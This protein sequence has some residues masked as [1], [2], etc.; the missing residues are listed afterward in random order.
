MDF[1][2]RLRV[3]RHHHDTGLALTVQF[4][5][6]MVL[7]GGCDTAILTLETRDSIRYIS[8]DLC[9]RTTLC[10][11]FAVLFKIHFFFHNHRDL[12]DSF[13]FVLRC[14]HNQMLI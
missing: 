12:R 4:G 5:D 2:D 8:F 13:L 3:Y 10:S 11:C 9:L 6:S 7:L 14:L 1:M